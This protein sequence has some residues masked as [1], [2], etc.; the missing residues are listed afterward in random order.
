MTFKKF[1]IPL[2]VFF[3]GMIGLAVLTLFLPNIHQQSQDAQAAIGEEVVSQYWGLDW[4]FSSDR[5]LIYVIVFLLIIFTVG[6]V[7]IKRK[8]GNN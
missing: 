8:W 6:A 4:I 2:I 1:F 5:L 3:W 7:W